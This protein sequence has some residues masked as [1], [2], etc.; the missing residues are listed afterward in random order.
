M[1]M[2]VSKWGTGRMQELRDVVHRDEGVG[3][4][5]ERL[6]CTMSVGLTAF[7]NDEVS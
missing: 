4:T 6:E 3:E 5:L 7:G 2:H 1:L